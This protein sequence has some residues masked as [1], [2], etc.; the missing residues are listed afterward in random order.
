MVK[1]NKP[2]RR[3]GVWNFINDTHLYRTFFCAWWFNA[4]DFS[5]TFYM[6]FFF[7]FFQN[8]LCF[9]RSTRVRGYREVSIVPDR[10]TVANFRRFAPVRDSNK[11]RGRFSVKSVC[12]LAL[13][14][15][16]S[17]L[18]LRINNDRPNECT[19]PIARS[20]SLLASL[21]TQI[22]TKSWAS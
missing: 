8:S 2:P 7:L 13:L 6:L 15:G 4:V 21:F 17:T 11:K 20:T 12:D 18:L 5:D 10:Q 22:A 9:R 14:T 19:F 3:Y 1:K 16:N